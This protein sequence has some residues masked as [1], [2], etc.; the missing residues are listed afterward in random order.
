MMLGGEVDELLRD[1]VRQDIPIAFRSAEDAEVQAIASRIYR[2]PA[3]SWAHPARWRDWECVVRRCD[4]DTLRQFLNDVKSS[5]MIDVCVLDWLRPLGGIVSLSDDGGSAVL[6]YDDRH[7]HSPEP[8]KRYMCLCKECCDCGAVWIS[9]ACFRLCGAP[10]CESMRTPQV[11]PR[12]RCTCLCRYP[13]SLDEL[14]E[15]IRLGDVRIPQLCHYL[16]GK[17]EKHCTDAKAR[18][19]ARARA[20]AQGGGA[21]R[22]KARKCLGE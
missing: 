17:T 3:W 8:N 22:N 14:L 18:A 4:L 21:R 20:R 12:R 6:Q 19:R 1:A 13:R 15:D 5:R 16:F 11:P 7:P 10:G 9:P 2:D